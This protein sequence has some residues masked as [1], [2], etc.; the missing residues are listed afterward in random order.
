MASQTVRTTLSLPVDLLAAVDQAVQAGKARSRNELVRIALERELAA[1]KRAV[2]DAAFAEMA[3]DSDFQTEAK[4][5]ASE[6]EDR[7]HGS[8]A[9]H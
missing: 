8:P 4:A 9:H 3:Q 5:I 6:F 2:I 1:Q 7:C